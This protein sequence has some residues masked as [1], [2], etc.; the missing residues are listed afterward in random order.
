MSGLGTYAFKKGD[1][2]T[3]AGV[4]SVN[5][6]AFTDTGDLQ[7]GVRIATGVNNPFLSLFLGQQR[8]GGDLSIAVDPNDSATVYVC[9]GDQQ[10]GTY[11]LLVRKSTDSGATW[12]GNL[13]TIANASTCRRAGT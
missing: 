6:V 10:G 7:Q 2:F 11:S 4:N 12:S 5:P 13:R 8:I 3:V 1:I 9:Y